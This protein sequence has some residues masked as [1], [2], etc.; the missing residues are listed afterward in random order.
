[1]T[2]PCPNKLCPNYGNQCWNCCNSCGKSILW[3]PQG[4]DPEIKYSGPK[5]LNQDGS[6]HRCMLQGVKQYKK[7]TGNSIID[8]INNSKELYDFL[9][10]IHWTNKNLLSTTNKTR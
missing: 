10:N 6:T 8:N 4:L 3:R 2:Y 7:I 9:K 5:P 1:M